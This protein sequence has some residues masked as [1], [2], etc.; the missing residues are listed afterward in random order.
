MIKRLIFDVDG[1]LITGIKF[2][3]FVKNALK[4]VNAY[5]EE[6]LANF[7]NGIKTY[8]TIY[9]NYNKKDYIE[10]MSK[11]IN[12]KLDDEFLDIFF[13]EL[14]YA[15]QPK[16]EE[17]IHTISEL[18]KKY[19][20]VILTNYFSK[21]QLNRLNNL[22]IGKYF[23]ECHGEKLIKPNKNSY[24][25]ACGNNKPEE[26]V[27]IGDDPILD[28][29]SAQKYGLNTIFVNTKNIELK[30]INTVTVENVIEISE[31]TIEKI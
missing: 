3:D 14:K 11:Y 17:L 2:T 28:I 24:L 26:C 30:D 15:I 31:K 12:K 8:E 9:D 27:M 5:S 29:V 22:G 21:S 16:S 19:E 10:H 20:M 18:S 23:S 7:M 4:R 25:N 6:N 13:D 1:T